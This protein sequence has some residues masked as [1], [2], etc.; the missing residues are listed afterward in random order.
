MPVAL[1]ERPLSPQFRAGPA[2]PVLKLETRQ[3]MRDSLVAYRFMCFAKL[4]DVA[5]GI[6]CKAAP[7]HYELSELLLHNTEHVA[8]EMF[9]ESGKS[10]YAL[11]S[12]PLY[13]CSYPHRDRSYIVLIMANATLAISKLDEI[14]TEYKS[15]P[16]VAHNLVRIVKDSG[17]AFAVDVRDENGQIINVRI[18]AYGK[19]AA[20]RGLNNN[21]R[22]PQI[23]LCDDVQT[24]EDAESDS[25][26]KSDWKWFLSEV[27]FLGKN[28]RIFFIGNNLGDKCIAERIF[29]NAEGLEK[30]K[31]K[32][33]KVPIM[34]KNE[35]GDDVP[36][37]PARDTVE[38]ILKERNDYVKLGEESIWYAEKMCE[39]MA[40]G[41]RIFR[42]DDYTAYSKE[43][44]EKILETPGRITACMDMASSVKDGS[45]YRAITVVGTDEENRWLLLDNR[46]G[47]WDTIKMLDEIFGVVKDYRLTSFGIETGQIYQIL[48]PIILEEQ[49]RR[50]IFFVLVELQHS[51]IGSKLERIKMLQPRFKAHSLLF[52]DYYV[53]WLYEVKIELAGIARDSIKSKFVDCIDS[54]AMQI[55]IAR[56]VAPKK[57]STEELKQKYREALRG[58]PERVHLAQLE[59]KLKINPE[60][61]LEDYLEEAE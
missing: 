18:E 6:E 1:V 59:D 22:R 45:C 3:K 2:E 49:R 57:E 19:G 55:Q 53:P 13:C 35:L 5:A 54:L 48:T 8:I 56:Y 26:S 32:T 21:D 24:R 31:F 39:A 16:L 15:N 46:Y 9:R 52:P 12:F 14:R 47:R 28:S 60:K 17:N 30:I 51:T 58:G 43:E 20:I 61:M 10:T 50:N 40:E 25:V 44:R 11:K 41:D 7:F 4:D 38:D 29:Q 23:V 33:I 27:I 37:W 34:V 36:S 42:E